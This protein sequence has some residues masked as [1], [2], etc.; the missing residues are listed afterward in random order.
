MKIYIEFSD[1]KNPWG[2]GNQFLKNLKKFFIQK[3]IIII[4]SFEN[5]RRVLALKKNSLV[6]NLF[7][8]LMELLICITISLIKEI[9]LLF[10]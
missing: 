10:F 7:K 1:T 2:G 5:F 8:E 6:K 9:C 3:N 4:N